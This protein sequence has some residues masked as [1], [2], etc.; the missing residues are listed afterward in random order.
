MNI[1]HS[2]ATEQTQ[3]AVSGNPNLLKFLVELC[4]RFETKVVAH[5]EERVTREHSPG[6][7]LVNQD[8]TPFGVVWVNL[9]KN[10]ADELVPQ[11]FFSASFVAKDRG[12]GSDRYIRDSFNMKQIIK[13]ISSCK[14]KCGGSVKTFLKSKFRNVPNDY[15]SYLANKLDIR[16]SAGIELS[17]KSAQ[18]ML[19]F[20][21]DNVMITD[22]AVLDDLKSKY[23]KML[24][25]N[26]AREQLNEHLTGLMKSKFYYMLAYEGAPT[27]VGTISFNKVN[28]DNYEIISHGD[29]K[30]Y[31]TFDEIAQDH[32]D[33]A[34]TYNM[35]R[36]NFEQDDKYEALKRAAQFRGFESATKLIDM[37]SYNHSLDVL[38]NS[39]RVS[40][41]V[42]FSKCNYFLAP[43]VEVSNG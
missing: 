18:A 43:I 20:F 5:N 6:V 37:D 31:A 26:A 7:F 13:T 12:R 27:M 1:Y 39:E 24:K 16:Y 23:Q 2:V 34:V 19:K 36:I 33:L 40:G 30:L 14:D 35:W 21:Y 38:T 9:A 15:Y 41:Y 28:D 25:V 42:M 22:S 10:K 3:Q 17:N 11:Y 8:N 32:P 4:H 29:I